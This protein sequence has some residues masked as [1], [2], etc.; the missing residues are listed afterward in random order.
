MTS[1]PETILHRHI[2]DAKGANPAFR[3]AKVRK[4]FPSKE[5]YRFDADVANRL[6]QQKRLNIYNWN[7]G[8]RRGKEGAIEK[9]IAGKWHIIT[10]Q[11]SIEHLDHEYLTNR[12]YVTHYGG[13]AI[14]FNKDTSH[15]DIKSY[16]CLSS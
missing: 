6:L 13:C 8:P 4:H 12:F 2:V 5:E 3:E 16:F 1:D 14:Q 11:A 10:L 15:Q 7:P 9:H